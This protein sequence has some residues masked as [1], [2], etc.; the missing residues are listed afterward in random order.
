MY[1][2]GANECLFYCCKCHPWFEQINGAEVVLAQMN[3]FLV[4]IDIGQNKV[5]MN[6]PYNIHNMNICNGIFHISFFKALSINEGETNR[7]ERE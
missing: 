2:N 3:A 6:K 4:Q 7:G 1:N 5:P